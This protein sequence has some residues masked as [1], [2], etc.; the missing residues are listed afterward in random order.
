MRGRCF[1]EEKPK[2][3]AHNRQLTLMRL[4]VVKRQKEVNMNTRILL[5][6]ALLILVPESSVA[7]RIQV[8]TLKGG[9]VITDLGYNVKVNK[10][11]SLQRTW[12]VLN[13]SSA[14][15]QLDSAGIKTAYGKR[16][17]KYRPVGSVLAS[18]AVSAFQVRYLLYDMFGE[19]L[20]TLSGTEVVDVAAGASYPLT[21]IGTWRAWENDVSKL[22]TV[23][24]FVAQVRTAN[25]KIWRYDKDAIGDQL[26]QI[27]LR[28]TSGVFEPSKEK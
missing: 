12:V 1:F 6:L 18:K 5:V 15:I 10:G 8:T 4:P 17:Y 22:L 7:Q 26:N 20:K 11:S 21:D 16:N 2:A 3:Y 13:D 27:H 9:S 25:G 14:P 19:H 23:V 24:V 28:V